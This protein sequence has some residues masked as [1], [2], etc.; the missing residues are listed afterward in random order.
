MGLRSK[1][2]VIL[3]VSYQPEGP[4][5]IRFAVQPVVSMIQ[6]KSALNDIWIRRVWD[7]NYIILS[8]H[9]VPKRDIFKFMIRFSELEIVLL[10]VYRMA[11]LVPSN[12]PEK[13]NPVYRIFTKPWRQKCNPFH[14]TNSNFWV[15]YAF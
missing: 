15:T 8:M 1:V 2:I 11:A 6:I 12:V 14:S 13:K 3:Y 5:F 7:S 9:Q 4:N 10:K